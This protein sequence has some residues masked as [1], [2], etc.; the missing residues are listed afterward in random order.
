MEITSALHSEQHVKNELAKK[1]GQLQ[2]KLGDLKE[3]VT[4]APTE[5]G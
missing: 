5:K 4:L 2:E 1:V 3:T